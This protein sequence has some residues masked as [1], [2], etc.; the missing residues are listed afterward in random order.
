MKNNRLF[1]L[2]LITTVKVVVKLNSRTQTTKI[3][4][5]K[6]T[7]TNGSGNKM[8]NKLNWKLIAGLAGLNLAFTS[9]AASDLELEQLK[10]QIQEQWG[11]LS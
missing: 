3:Q 10:K 4:K 5:T 7:V 8:K 9:L 6:L 2:D 11:G 1:Y